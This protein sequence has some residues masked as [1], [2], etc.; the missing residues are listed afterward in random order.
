ML[1]SK[2]I[3]LLVSVDVPSKIKFLRLSPECKLFAVAVDEGNVSS[4]TN[5]VD[6]QLPEEVKYCKIA[7]S[8]NDE[9]ITSVK[10]P[11]A[12]T[13]VTV[14]PEAGTVTDTF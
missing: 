11:K 9:A 12:V 13:L 3:V 4:S 2:S 8:G 1:A 7:P 14:P 10:S 5:A 6:T